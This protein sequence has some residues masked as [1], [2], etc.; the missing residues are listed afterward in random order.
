V[1]P[2][3]PVPE[4]VGGLASLGSDA[5]EQPGSALSTRPSPSSSTP[6]E[7]AGAAVVVVV[8]VVWPEELGCVV[9]VVPWGGA[10]PLLA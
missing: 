9:V 2:V 10:P 8:E 4:D 6:F 3:L 7:Q 5:L 1:E